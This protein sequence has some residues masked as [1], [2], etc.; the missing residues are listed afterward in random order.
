MPFPSVAGAAGIT[1][2]WSTNDG[3]S[4]CPPEDRC[5]SRPS[6]HAVYSLIGSARLKG[7]RALYLLLADT[8][9]RFHCPRLG[10]RWEKHWSAAPSLPPAGRRERQR[11]Q[12]RPSAHGPTPPGRRHNRRWRGSSNICRRPHS[13]R[14]SRYGSCCTAR[15]NGTARSI[16]Q[17][18][19]RHYN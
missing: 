3:R 1:M 19:A 18:S 15:A 13:L 5:R 7:L 16:I 10:G 17:W 4:I 2:F 9:D 11:D 8:A 6:S 12:H 14:A